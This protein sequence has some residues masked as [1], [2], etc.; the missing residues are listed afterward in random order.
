ID[1]ICQQTIW[2]DTSCSEVLETAPGV[3]EHSQLGSI[4]LDVLATESRKFLCFLTHNRGSISKQL[5]RIRVRL[6]RIVPRPSKRHHKW[7]RQSDFERNR[8]TSTRVREFL[9]CQRTQTPNLVDDCVLDLDFG[10]LGGLVWLV[11]TLPG[12]RKGGNAR[13]ARND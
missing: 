5:E 12:P 2:I 8:S 13:N 9:T 6:A 3:A 4:N 7:T 10:L 1:T 11:R